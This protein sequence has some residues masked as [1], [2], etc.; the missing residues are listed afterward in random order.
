M[1]EENKSGQGQPRSR[2][3]DRIG[4][5][6]KLHSFLR[7]FYADVR[8]HNL[9]GPVFNEH[10]DNWPEHIDKICEF[11]SGIM[12]GPSSY[13]GAM[14]LAHFPLGLKEEHFE[15]WLDLWRRNCRIHLPV[16]EAEDMITIAEG[17]G[18]RLRMMI[19]QHDA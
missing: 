9:I 2:L 19:K 16:D 1:N 4:G 15:A 10:V 7:H 18:Q 3:Y 14:P 13:S 8:Q 12:G 6:A 11:W 17:I 5:R